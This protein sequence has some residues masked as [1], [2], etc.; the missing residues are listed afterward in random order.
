MAAEAVE[1]EAEREAEGPLKEA[2]RV[3]EQD[4]VREDG[5]TVT[6]VGDWDGVRVDSVADTEGE[7][8]LLGWVGVYEAE[9]DADADRNESV[10]VSVTLRVG[11]KPERVWEV[12]EREIDSV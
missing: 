8:D 3:P 6:S 1:K 2:V 7:A 11:L 10:E 5:V 4:R 12:K 9:G